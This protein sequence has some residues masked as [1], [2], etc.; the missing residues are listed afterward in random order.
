MTRFQNPLGASLPEAKTRELV[1]LL[2][3]HELPL[4]EDDPYGALRFH[5]EPAPSLYELGLQLA[6]DVNRNHVVYCSSFSKTLVPGLRD[7]WIDSDLP[8]S[9]DPVGLDDAPAA[10]GEPHP[11]PGLRQASARAWDAA[12]RWMGGSPMLGA[13]VCAVVSLLVLGGI[14]S[15][16]FGGG[17]F[18]GGGGGF[19]GGGGGFGGIG[20]SSGGGFGG[21]GRF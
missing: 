19:G 14:L 9:T 6:G 11:W 8:T 20:G 15:G 12:R 13:F 17:G 3:R 7:A 21:G 4:I 18:G 16:G 1:R 5:G 2:A 10:T